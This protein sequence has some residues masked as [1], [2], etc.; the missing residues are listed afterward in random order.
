MKIGYARVS[1]VD[2]TPALQ[3]DALNNAGCERVYTDQGLS[4][5]ATNRPALV[6]CLASLAPGDVLTVWKLDRLGRSMPDLVNIVA[7]LGKRGVGFRSLSE[8]IDSTTPHGTLLFH[9]MGGLA[10]FERALIVERTRAGLAA[11]RL[12][13]SI[14]GRRP[15]LTAEKIAHARKLL[16]AGEPPSAIRKTLGISKATF[17]RHIHPSAAMIDRLADEPT[18]V[19]TVCFPKK[20]D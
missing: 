13:G 7:D 5:L 17:Y 2:Q 19:P 8:A 6:E 15:L 4:G 3:L 16:A 14:P 1:T 11:A 20:A 18:G 10:Q 9:V 12:R